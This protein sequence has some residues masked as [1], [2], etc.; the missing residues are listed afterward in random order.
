MRKLLSSVNQNNYVDAHLIYKLIQLLTAE[1]WIIEAQTSL[2]FTI[3]QLLV[4]E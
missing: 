1:T 3:R 4:N 2:N